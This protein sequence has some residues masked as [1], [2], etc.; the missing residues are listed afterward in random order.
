MWKNVLIKTES[1]LFVNKKK[2][3]SLRSRAERACVKARFAL[4]ESSLYSQ[5]RGSRIRLRSS[6]T[7]LPFYFMGSLKKAKLAKLA[8]A[9]P[10][11]REL[12]ICTNHKNRIKSVASI[13]NYTR[14][15]PMKNTNSTVESSTNLLIENNKLF[16]NFCFDKGR[17]KN[18]VL[19]FLKKYGENRTIH[20]VEELKNVG[21]DYATKAGI[22]LG[23]DDLKIPPKKSFLLL[24][25]EKIAT[26][27][28]NQYKKG[29][30]TGVERYQRLIDTWHRTSEI[31]KQEVIENFVETDVLNPVY[32]MAFS[33]ARGNISQVRQL[34]GMR[35]LMADPKGQI[36]DF[37]IRSNFREGLTLT[38]Y[39]ISS[40]GARKGIVD[41]ALRTANAGY[42]TRRLVDVAQHVII[43][44]FD[45]GTQKGI[46]LNDMKDGNKT[47][48]SLQTRLVGRILGRDIFYEK[49]ERV[50]ANTLLAS[51]N[52]EISADL[53][54]TI[55]QRFSKVFV[56]SPLTCETKKLVCQLCYGWSL[57]QGNLVSI[58]EAIGVV[59]AQSIG[60]PGTQLTMR[61]FH[62]G[63]VFSGDISEQIRAPFD[64]IICYTG[65]IP[66]TLIRTPEGK[67][68]FLTKSEGSFIVKSENKVSKKYKIPSYT[69]LFLR[70]GAK[71]QEK[72]VL[73]QITNI[74]ARNRNATDVAELTIKSELEGQLILRSLIL[75]EKKIAPMLADASPDPASGPDDADPKTNIRHSELSEFLKYYDFYSAN[76]LETTEDDR[77]KR[78]RTELV[79]EAWTWGNAW[80]L[81]GKIYQLNIPSSFF[82]IKGDYINRSSYMNRVNWNSTLRSVVG[83]SELHLEI[84]SHGKIS[85]PSLPA[86]WPLSL[87]GVPWKTAKGER[88]EFSVK[89]L[90]KQTEAIKSQRKNKA[91]KNSLVLNNIMNLGLEK[92]R[93][94]KL[95]Y[96]LKL[97]LKTKTH[98]L[99]GKDVLLL[100]RSLSPERDNEKSSHSILMAHVLAEDEQK[101]RNPFS[102]SNCPPSGA[103]SYLLKWFPEHSQTKTG[104]LIFYENQTNYS[105]TNEVSCESVSTLIAKANAS[106]LMLR[107]TYS[108]AWFH[109]YANNFVSLL[110]RKTTLSCYS[111]PFGLRWKNTGQRSELAGG[112]LVRPLTYQYYGGFRSENEN[113][114][115]SSV[116][117]PAKDSYPSIE[118]A[119]STRMSVAKCFVN[120]LSST[121]SRARLRSPSGRELKSFSHRSQYSL[122]SLSSPLQ[123]NDSNFVRLNSLWVLALNKLRLGVFNKQGRAERVGSHA[124]KSTKKI[125]KSSLK[126]R[127]VFISEILRRQNQLKSR[128]S[129]ARRHR[130]L[131]IPQEFYKLSNHRIKTTHFITNTRTP[132]LLLTNRQ[133][134][135]ALSHNSSLVRCGAHRFST[136]V[137]ATLILDSQIK[138]HAFFKDERSK[139][140]SIQNTTKSSTKSFESNF[141]ITYQKRYKNY[142]EKN[143]RTLKS[144]CY[145]TNFYQK[146]DP[147][148]IFFAEKT[149]KR[150]VHN[151]VLKQNNSRTHCVR[152][153]HF[154]RTSGASS[155]YARLDSRSE[156]VSTRARKLFKFLKKMCF[157]LDYAPDIIQQTFILFFTKRLHNSH[158]IY[159][160]ERKTNHIK[161]CGLFITVKRAEHVALPYNLQRSRTN[162]PA[163]S[164]GELLNS[165]C[166]SSRTHHKIQKVRPSLYNG[167]YRFFVELSEP[168]ALNIRLLASAKQQTSMLYASHSGR[169]YSPENLLTPGQVVSF[170]KSGEPSNLAF[171][172]GWIYFPLKSQNILPY[173]KTLIFPGQIIANNLC[174]ANQIV[175]L[176]CIKISFV[177]K[178]DKKKDFRAHELSTFILPEN[179]ETSK[180]FEF[181]KCSDRIA[182][183]NG[184]LLTMSATQTPFE[185]GHS[186]HHSHS[187]GDKPTPTLWIQ[188][189][190]S[191]RFPVI[192]TKAK[193]LSQDNHSNT[194]F[195][196]ENGDHF[197]LLIR[198]VTEQ[199]QE[200]INELKNEI[201]IFNK[202]SS[203]GIN[204][205][206]NISQYNIGRA[207]KTI[208][209]C[210]L[211]KA[212][213]FF[214]AFYLR[215]E[216][217][218]PKFTEARRLA[219]TKVNKSVN[220]RKTSYVANYKAEQHALHVY[221]KT[222]IKHGRIQN[223]KF[224]THRAHST[225][226][227]RPCYNSLQ[228]WKQNKT[229]LR[230]K[231]RKSAQAVT[232]FPNIDFKVI[233]GGSPE[234]RP[235]FL[236]EYSS[237]AKEQRSKGVYAKQ[238]D[239]PLH[240]ERT[241]PKNI[242]PRS[243]QGE[244]SED[245]RSEFVSTASVLSMLVF[246]KPIN[247]NPLL[248]TYENSYGATAPFKEL[249]TYFGTCASKTLGGSLETRP[250][251]R[252]ACINKQESFDNKEKTTHVLADF[253]VTSLDSCF[254]AFLSFSLNSKYLKNQSRTKLFA[255]KNQIGFKNQYLISSLSI[256][257][258][259]LLSPIRDSFF[260]IAHSKSPFS[261][262]NYYSPFEGEILFFG[263]R[264]DD[265]STAIF[266]E[267]NS[268]D[269]SQKINNS[270]IRGSLSSQIKKL[271]F[272]KKTKNPK[273][274]QMSQF[275][276]NRAHGS[277]AKRNN[278]SK[279]RNCLILTKNDCISYYLTSRAEVTKWKHSLTHCVR[280]LHFYRTSGA[281]LNE[282]RTFEGEPSELQENK[283]R[284]S[285][286][287]AYVRLNKN[288]QSNYY[289]NDIIIALDKGHL[290]NP[291][292]R[293][294]LLK[295][296]QSSL[297]PESADSFVMTEKTVAKISIL[298][299]GTPQPRDR[300]EQLGDYVAYGDNINFNIAI[301]TPGQII[302][303]NNQKITIRKGQPIFISPKAILHKYNGDFIEKKTPVITLAY[304]QLKTGDIIQGIPK[305][306]QFFEA[307]TTKRGRLFRDSLPNL[308]KGLYNR[309]NSLLPLEQAVRQSFYKIQQIIVDGVQRVYKSQG[310]TIADKH[311]EVIVKQMTCKVRILDGA[312]TG[313]FPGEIVDI[314]FVEK[315]NSFLMKKITYEPIV[316]GITR[317]SLEVDS[318]L[319][320]ASFQQTTRVLSKAAIARK[321]DFLKG[322]KENIMLGN[323]MPAGTGY[324]VSLN[325]KR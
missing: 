56:R 247:F 269:S 241:N 121:C 77:N 252:E 201:T 274:K 301:Q 308:L 281:S 168:R 22:S 111:A 2:Q 72:E 39:I 135:F 132:V 212:F 219:K 171:K 65:A 64:G 108:L 50:E 142:V 303:I 116:F 324:L 182:E 307:R 134:T 191:P 63:G 25:A 278:V 222:R 317:A 41:T 277:R 188:R 321:K 40:Y 81:A 205:V 33:G 100:L 55:A 227:A 62:T 250:K 47:I 242:M 16:W 279:E 152:P 311:L 6:S 34:V 88:S 114:N 246:R 43:S 179:N 263:D 315:I 199:S 282:Q 161:A 97:A 165:L 187:A 235:V 122:S 76:A 232:K 126:T 117:Q 70:N 128:T 53:A 30:I 8:H 78:D 216:A 318:F 109:K 291:S 221:A 223:N 268:R 192:A 166:S 314:E 49:R 193:M 13:M 90:A 312:Q 11:F 213:C 120:E 173:H 38:E 226:Y 103:F 285:R 302:H 203:F 54:F 79:Y 305:V 186:L 92:I 202:N 204:Q 106:A 46:F 244:R 258:S 115:E 208:F 95:T 209:R 85:E 243:G 259:S 183:Q 89:R 149:L 218:R 245:E 45:C 295:S 249:K 151:D 177:N 229:S 140:A 248:I 105:R 27:T 68:A 184:L 200:R 210:E 19:W 57:A 124:S 133:A 238:E 234:A 148:G 215:S 164:T 251:T 14:P 180:S 119:L 127:N 157:Y 194:R 3:N 196:I 233:S 299:A 162:S 31:L 96:F 197:V 87:R 225:R 153:L 156:Y 260:R 21:F 94:Q 320:A 5:I 154:Y 139:H 48:H 271:A 118:S 73:A 136:H 167:Q 325:D 93:F 283:P 7:E 265:V 264:T 254:S 44:N 145:F 172:K 15:Q 288:K 59:A 230:N 18:M 293:K 125:R 83:G 29:E 137:F 35:G 309:Y 240:K 266:N 107:F 169:V 99:S 91:H 102:T 20:L 206:P 289:I 1:I 143:V 52:D 316:L 67:I 170:N 178:P 255:S 86:S 130:L 71:I 236:G 69:L 131:F 66:G 287:F 189:R 323:L 220:T 228:L 159:A 61:T 101:K 176:E 26:Q 239:E 296:S 36:L 290:N 257:S 12:F 163:T 181:G 112:P 313:F 150:A 322:L 198:N 123:T 272:K 319:S 141:Y 310:V 82:P 207:R 24:E 146:N 286:P 298:D 147:T 284:F 10:N 80:I 129:R 306:E 280:P 237:K 294:Y 267:M 276:V 224:L 32:M 270:R 113:K 195:S 214:R 84:H 175:Y 217:H 292:V 110:S 300:S 273:R 17:L 51:R 211:H 256:N 104:G 297:A 262:T 58:G 75:R 190:T 275:D 4:F 9:H 160:K 155:R 42:L 144:F 60:E 261:L 28:V 158:A 253:Y 74:R 174:F 231:Q 98:L 23:I 37:P 138:R 304:Q 185:R